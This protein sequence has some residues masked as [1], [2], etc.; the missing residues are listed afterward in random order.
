M[1]CSST[2]SGVS[3]RSRQGRLKSPALAGAIKNNFAAA[4]ATNPNQDAAD[5]GQSTALADL[6]RQIQADAKAGK[7]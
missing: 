3:E 5:A 4:D 6:I 1:R 2:A 7:K